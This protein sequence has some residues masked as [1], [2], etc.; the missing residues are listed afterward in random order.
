MTQYLIGQ[1]CSEIR[2]LLTSFFSQ[3]EYSLAGRKIQVGTVCADK[4]DMAR[5][6]RV[7]AP[8]FPHHIIQR[9]NRRQRVFF[10]DDDR[11]T[12]LELLEKYTK[13]EGIK[14]AAYCLMDNHVHIV[15]TPGAQSRLAHAF[16][17]AHRLYTRRINFRKSWRGY[18]WQGRFIS[19][20]MDEKHYYAAVRYVER[21]PVRANL[22]ERAEEYVWS[23][24]RAHVMGVADPLLYQ[25]PWLIEVVGNWSTYLRTSEKEVVKGIRKHARTGRPL[26]NDS[27]IEKLETELCRTLKQQKPGPKVGR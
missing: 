4:V 21:N 7:I 14:I 16:G 20:P 8:G 2:H 10:N 6:A 19:Y 17:E 9:G 27:F 13:T 24:A 18:L 25:D 5:L 1:Y 23:S 12:Y 11:R 15:A 26:G 22:V 3:L